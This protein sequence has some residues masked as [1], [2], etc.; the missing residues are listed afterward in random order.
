MIRVDVFLP[1]E[2][3]DEIIVAAVEEKLGMTLP[4]N[5]DPHLLRLAVNGDGQKGLRFKASVG[6]SLDEFTEMR[7]TKR[8]KHAFPVPDLTYDLLKKACSIRP[9][10]VG[11]GP[12]GLFAAL[13]LAEAGCRP[14]ILERGEPMEKRMETVETFK[15][16]GALCAESNIQFG[17]GG[18]GTFSDGKLKP[19]AMDARKY[20][21]LSE[22]VAAGAPCRILYNAAPHVGTD[23]LCG[24]IRRIREKIESLGGEVRFGARLSGLIRKDGRLVGVRYCQAG[25]EE[26]LAAERVILATGHSAVDV[27]ELLKRENIPL[28]ARGFG[29]GVRIEHPRAHIDRVRYGEN[30]PAILG[31]ASYHLVEHLENGRSAY[32]FCMCPGGTVVAATSEA[33][34]VVTNGMS[35]NA[36]DGENSNAAFL[37]SVTP[38]D[39]GSDD[40]LA[41]LAFQRKYERKAFTL[42]GDYR[43]PVQ[44]LGDFMEGRASRELGC[45]SPTYPRGT[46]LCDLAECLPTFVTETLRAAIPRFEAY[47]NGFYL[48]DAVMCGVETRSTSPVRI[49]RDEKGEAIGLSGLYPCGEGAGYA[50]GILSSAVDGMRA[51]EHVLETI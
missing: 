15:K 23:L 41:G 2:Y 34:S 11:S 22:F 47:M 33:G 32:S 43:A 40:P 16:G 45:V 26:E 38:A 24:I 1:L 20:K 42:G 21:I 10:V 36:R 25:R 27:F 13:V 37:V 17:E 5:A 28:E 51:A 46:I 48:P 8:R 49:L 7:L 29:L 30:P 19:G 4:E 6:V 3:N 50:G 14:I 18:A 9:V 31:A 35:E 39:F 12:S 44:L